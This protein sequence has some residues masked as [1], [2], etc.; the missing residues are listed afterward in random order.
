M[1]KVSKI[2]TGSLCAALLLVTP[3]IVG[4]SIESHYRNQGFHYSAV[5]FPLY[6]ASVDNLVNSRDD[7][8]L[9]ILLEQIDNKS[10]NKSEQYFDNADNIRSLRKKYSP[11]SLGLKSLGIKDKFDY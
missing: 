9:M 11:I 10:E 2:L 5:G 4:R 1:K 6:C 7:K 3:E 8:G